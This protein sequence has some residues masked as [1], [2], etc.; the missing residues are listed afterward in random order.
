MDCPRIFSFI[1]PMPLQCLAQSQ[2]EHSP[3]TGNYS[4]LQHNSNTLGYSFNLWEMK[5]SAKA[6]ESLLLPEI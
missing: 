4:A 6:R 1:S 3:F 2:E 5:K